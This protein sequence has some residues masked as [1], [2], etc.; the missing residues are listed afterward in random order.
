M[1][2]QKSVL[3]VGDLMLD[4][5]VRGDVTRISPEAPVPIL[6]AREEGSTPGGAANAAHN[7]RALGA[8]VCLVGVVGRDAAGDALR[9]AL[10]AAAVET[11]FI[12]DDARPTTLKTR[13]IARGQQVVRIDRE[14][15]GPLSA[16]IR[17]A[18]TAAVTKRIAS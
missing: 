15:R 10:A 4:E 7:A 12:V 6:E 16:E 3:V 13:I 14:S 2:A 5:F 1:F 9:A 18:L 17:A 11:D 8:K